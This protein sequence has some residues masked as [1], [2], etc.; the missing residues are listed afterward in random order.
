[1]KL[2]GR[3]NPVTP[4]FLLAPAFLILLGLLVFPILW[5]AVVAMHDVKLTTI[6]KEWQFVGF[7]HYIDI[8][9]DEYFYESLKVS[10]IFVG[11]SVL[12]QWLIGL[13]LAEL[14]SQRLRGTEM[15]RAIFILPWLFS[16][17]IVGF[18]WRWMYNDKFGL[19]NHILRTVGLSTVKW[20]ADPSMAPWSIV[21]SNVW[22]GTP[23]SMLF[24]GS[25]LATINQELYEAATVDGA[26]RWQT[27]TRITLPLLKPFIAVNLILITVWT[28]NLFGLQLTMT[29]GGPLYSTT[30]T[31]LYM[32][33]QAFE[34]GHL[35]IGASVGFMLLI[36]NGVLALLYARSMRAE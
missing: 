12:S 26:S 1:M 9:H 31:S 27:F 5:N 25:A 18:S 10:A 32:Y 19:I 36:I 33:R 21:V 6:L 14:L 20:L 24:M 29:G 22:F 17:V 23:F 4:Y 8:I 2:Q 15:F 11:G 30:T 35:S 13:L 28:V 34:M 7:K 16:A 3:E